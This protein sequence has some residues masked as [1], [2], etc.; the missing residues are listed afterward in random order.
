MN[1]AANAAI[2]I[3]LREGSMRLSMK[4]DLTEAVAVRNCPESVARS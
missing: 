4:V 1:P 2:S 3:V